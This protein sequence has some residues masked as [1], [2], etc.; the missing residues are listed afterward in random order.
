VCRLSADLPLAIA[1]G[2]RRAEIET[3]LRADGLRGAFLAIV[4]ADDCTF[5]KPDPEPYLTAMARLSERFP[6]L[7][8]AQCLV[9][10]DSVAGIASGLAAG[11]RV[12]GVAHS[13]APEK[14]SAAHR[15][16]TSLEGLERADLDALF[17]E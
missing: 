15:V 10:E 6:D 16:V 9:F 4:G 12:V 3:I 17:T 8:A 7:T 5:T 2:A 11:M 14:L 1:S 13:Y